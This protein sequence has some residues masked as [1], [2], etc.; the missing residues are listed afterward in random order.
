MSFR[1]ARYLTPL[2]AAVVAAVAMPAEASA[3]RYG[4]RTLKVGSRGGDVK[5][6]QR[7][8]GSAG[9][10]VAREGDFGPKTRRALRATESELEL[11]AD[12]IATAR[13]QRAIRLA[14][15]D[16]GPGGAT[17]DPDP[18]PQQVVP[19]AKGSVTP[20]GFAVSPGSAPRAVKQVIAA[21]NTIAKEP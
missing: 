20:D 17:Y 7:Y 2:L 14:V 18:P 11:R 19:G 15:R 9:H 21:G 13:E 16:P 8:L 4:S 5:E 10:R 3:A 1:A 6:L 12:G